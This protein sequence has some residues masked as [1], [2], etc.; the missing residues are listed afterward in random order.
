MGVKVTLRRV[1]QD[2][3]SGEVITRTFDNGTGWA[4][5]E[6]NGVQALSVKGNKETPAAYVSEFLADSVESVEFV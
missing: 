1:D 5:T 3:M 6:E 4:F 2:S